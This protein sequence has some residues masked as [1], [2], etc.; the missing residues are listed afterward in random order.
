MR[1]DAA[2]VLRQGG[3]HVQ[4]AGNAS[5]AMDSLQ[6]EIIFDLLFTDI[7]LGIGINGIELALLAL[8]K[9][10]RLKVLVTTGDTLKD[11]LPEVLGKIL[12]KPYSNGDLLARVKHALA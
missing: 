1:L 4:E 3:Y 5:D 2:D 7:N 12:T 6:S 8:A 9:L 10:P 11:L